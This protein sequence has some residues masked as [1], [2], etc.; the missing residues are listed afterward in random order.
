MTHNSKLTGL[1]PATFTPMQ[2]DGRLRLERVGDIVDRLLA[3]RVAALFACGTTG[4]SVSLTGAERKATLEAF[5]AAAAGRIPVIAHVG[6]TAI[7]EAR[8]L[9]AHAQ[10]SGAAAFSAIPPF[11]FRPATVAALVDCMAEIAAGA[12]ELPFYYY[13]IPHLTGVGLD[14]ADF[15]R[16]ADGRIPNLAG[17]KFTAPMLFDL[18]CCAAVAPDRF[19]VLFGCDEMLLGAL[20]SGV[21]GA[22]GS[23]YNLA[24][25]LYHEMIACFEAGRLDEARRLQLLSARMVEA[26][27]R[28]RPLPALKSMMRLAGVDCGPTRSPL[29]AMSGS[30][31]AAL[32]RELAEIG[33]LEWMR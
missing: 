33:F 20:A 14:M 18:Q 1:V 5:I 19:D 32:E 10:A 25:R 16:Q 26:I 2:A 9:A 21:R 7:P 15:L 12:P 30:E 13:H 29:P 23:T 22:V 4:E 24:P 17:I 27:K 6:H 31:F 8:D 28:F 11:Y 3:H